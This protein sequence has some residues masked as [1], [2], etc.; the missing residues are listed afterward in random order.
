M[1]HRAAGA[2]DGGARLPLSSP[3]SADSGNHDG[4]GHK[5]H[6]KSRLADKSRYVLIGALSVLALCLAGMM[7]S[8]SSS[9]PSVNIRVDSPLPNERHRRQKTTRRDVSRARGSGTKAERNDGNGGRGALKPYAKVTKHAIQSEPQSDEQTASKVQTQHHGRAQEQRDTINETIEDQQNPIERKANDDEYYAS[10]RSEDERE[11]WR[12]RHARKKERERKM[13]LARDLGVDFQQ[14]LQVPVKSRTGPSIHVDMSLF[15]YEARP[16][17]V[18]IEFE[19]V[20]GV[21]LK[22][23]ID[24]DA[25]RDETDDEQRSD[26]S[27]EDDRETGSWNHIRVTNV[28]KLDVHGRGDAARSDRE[29]NPYPDSADY[30]KRLETIDV[31]DKKYA[32][33]AAEPIETEECK[34]KHDWQTQAFPTC[35]V[36]HEYSLSS[37]SHMM[38]RSLRNKLNTVEGD[39]DEK[40][41]ILGHGYWRDVWVLSKVS[42]AF[43]PKP[44]G[45]EELTVLKTLRYKHQFT[46]R[47]YDRHRKDSLASERLSKSPNVIDIYAYCSNS[48]VFEYGSGGGE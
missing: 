7:L 28:A 8:S 20:S 40:T 38:G 45:Q 47:N 23:S 14:T 16:R 13:G 10:S 25:A 1:R 18:Q 34:P 15:G 37:L 26:R 30:F 43:S 5:V 41:R 12:E 48:A 21:G 9:G 24:K 33:S 27:D 22:P 19:Q 46:D 39:G 31:A 3:P 36:M 6:R 29:I 2:T 44:T 17:H 32:K 35:N 4:N 42:T 11:T